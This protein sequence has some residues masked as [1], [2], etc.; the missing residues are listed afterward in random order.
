MDLIDELVRILRDSRN[1]VFFGGTGMATE[2]DVPNAHDEES[3]YSKGLNRKLRPDEMASHSF[4]VNHTEEFFEFFREHRILRNAEPN[5][6]HKALAELEQRGILK[7]VV[8]QDV[9]GLHQ[10]VGSKTVYELHGSILRWHCVE[11]GKV[12]PVGYVLQEENRPVPYCKDCDG[13][14]RPSVVL[15]EEEMDAKAAEGAVRAIR[16]ADTLIVGDVSLMAYPAAGLIAFFRGKH[17]VLISKM[18]TKADKHA[19]LAIRSGS[20]T[21][22]AEAV[23]R[24]KDSV[25]GTVYKRP[26]MPESKRFFA[27]RVRQWVLHPDNDPELV[28]E[29]RNGQ[30]PGLE[31]LLE[32]GDV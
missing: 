10:L 31:I 2:F 1:A 6:G 5:E 7:A 3:I 24:L 29:I 17:L 11:C 30:H 9:E 28:E 15:Y 20:G 14:V 23:G 25:N 13:I 16:E 4:L 26:D 18:E 27:K 8:T 19:E 22:L 32:K 12:Y 21:V